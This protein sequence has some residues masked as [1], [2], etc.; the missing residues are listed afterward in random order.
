MVSASGSASTTRRR[1]RN[2]L[3]HDSAESELRTA[4]P[5]EPMGFD[6]SGGIL[7]EDVEQR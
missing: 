1:T 6:T 5:I 3:T 4:A 7:G 2:R